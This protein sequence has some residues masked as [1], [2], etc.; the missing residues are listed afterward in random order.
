MIELQFRPHGHLSVLFVLWAGRR[1]FVQFGVRR[2]ERGQR[3]WDWRVPPKIRIR[4]R[5]SEREG[6]DA[7]LVMIRGL[8][9][10][11]LQ[12]RWSNGVTFGIIT[13]EDEEGS[14]SSVADV[15]VL[16]WRSGRDSLFISRLFNRNLNS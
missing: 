7:P 9:K 10:R 13:T 3:S 16:V 8:T 2:G 12:P 11:A 14:K 5:D 1:C 4:Q 15:V 6:R